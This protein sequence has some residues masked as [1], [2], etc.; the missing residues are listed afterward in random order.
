MTP[1]FPESESTIRVRYTGPL[2][3]VAFSKEFMER[4]KVSYAQ[5]DGRG[6]LLHTS[7]GTLFVEPEGD[8][9]VRIT[10]LS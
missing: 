4:F 8:G 10:K 5:K 2:S 6:V 9:I 1:T 3:P 7:A